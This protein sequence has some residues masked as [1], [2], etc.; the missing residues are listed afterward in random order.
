[1][2]ET[3]GATAQGYSAGVDWRSYNADGQ[4][5]SNVALTA[6]RADV[7]PI[8]SYFSIGQFGAGADI[9]DV[10]LAQQADLAD[11]PTMERYWQDAREL[12]KQIGEGSLGQPAALIV[13][14]T[15]WA[16][17]ELVD[18]RAAERV[19]AI[20]GSSGVPE[21]D[22]LP[23]TLAGFAQ[24]WITL[25]DRVAPD[26]ML[27]YPTADWG[28]GAKVAIADLPTRKVEISAERNAEFYDSLGA[29]F[30]FA[31]LE[32]A[33]FD[34]GYLSAERDDRGRSIWTPD[35]YVRHAAWVGEWVA[36]AGLR[37]VLTQIPFGNT[38]MRAVDD[39]AFHYQDNHV[40]TLV[41]EDDFA[42]LTGY[43][44]AGVIG[45]LFGTGRRKTTCPCDRAGDGVTNPPPVEGNAGRES[46]SADDDG[47]YWREQTKRLEE[48]GLA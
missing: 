48:G 43:R 6:T 37:M 36:D 45:L 33:G 5:A 1:M 31:T 39:T 18:E 30:D 26:V 35:D 19:E 10:A 38:Q 9:V 44:D 40:E 15:V 47:G 16:N 34:S 13:E 29:D 27:A 4:W 14:P 21:L 17:Q 11:P 42:T 46:L 32:I 28:S 12:V 24:G 41:G 2:L 7:L 8:F 25:R 22:G 23:D 20:V 3:S